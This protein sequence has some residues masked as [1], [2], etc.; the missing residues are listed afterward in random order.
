MHVDSI[1]V[2]ICEIV[3]QDLCPETL[4]L[5]QIL[6][7]C[8]VEGIFPGI[9]MLWDELDLRCNRLAEHAFPDAESSWKD[10]LQH[11]LAN[12]REH[13][14]LLSALRECAECYSL[15]QPI[16]QYPWD[17]VPYYLLN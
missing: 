6:Q 5:L 13:I 16:G 12:L 17:C 14:I 4:Q 1:A 11:C 7:A 10:N 8:L 3:A 15:Q 9:D 2:G